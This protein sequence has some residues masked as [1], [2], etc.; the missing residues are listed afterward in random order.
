MKIVIEQGNKGGECRWQVKL[1]QHC[2]SFRSETDAQAFVATLQTRLQ[3]PH[4]L[5]W[6]TSQRQAG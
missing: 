6:H 1:D 5:P 2:V 4:S 3:A